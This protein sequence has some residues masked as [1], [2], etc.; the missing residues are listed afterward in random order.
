MCLLEKAQEIA[1]NP[2]HNPQSQNFLTENLG[3]QELN[4]CPRSQ[5]LDYYTRYCKQVSN[6]RLYGLIPMISYY[7][8]LSNKILHFAFYKSMSSQRASILIIFLLRMWII[9]NFV[10]SFYNIFYFGHKRLYS[11][12][13]L[14]IFHPSYIQRCKIWG[15]HIT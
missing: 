12:R 14:N 9:F 1:L 6:P 7:I 13:K 4:N 15:T 10:H 11:F 2:H 5:D 3:L 8:I